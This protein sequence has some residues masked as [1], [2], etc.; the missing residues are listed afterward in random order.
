MPLP[1][2]PSDRSLAK[3]LSALTSR[4]RA[5]VY[6]QRAEGL[7]F[8]AIARLLR[9]R[10]ADVRAIALGAYARLARQLLSQPHPEGEP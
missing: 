5:V 3:A 6:L 9:C 10:E 4:E 7:D 1:P 8:K 2:N